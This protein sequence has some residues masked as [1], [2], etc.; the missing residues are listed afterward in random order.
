MTNLELILEV[1][2]ERGCADEDLLQ[3]AGSTGAMC[4]PGVGGKHVPEAD[5]ERLKAALR[6]DFAAMDANPAAAAS[7]RKAAFV[8]AR[9]RSRTN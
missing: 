9:K 7:A 2:R 6:A 8:S 4:F 3:L 1:M 5:V